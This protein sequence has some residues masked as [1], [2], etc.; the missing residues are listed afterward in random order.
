MDYVGANMDSDD[1]PK[2]EVPSWETCSDYCRKQAACTH[3]TWGRE[4]GDACRVTQEMQ[5]AGWGI[6]SNIGI[7]LAAQAF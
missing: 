7:Q 2:G 1:Y 6:P 3:W 5:I 4:G